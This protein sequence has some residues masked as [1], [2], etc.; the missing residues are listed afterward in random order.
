MTDTAR[1][2]CEIEI[3]RIHEVKL[4]PKV[5]AYAHNPEIGYYGDDD[6][7][8]YPLTLSETEEARDLLSD[9]SDDIPEPDT[10]SRSEQRAGADR[11]CR[12]WE[13]ERRGR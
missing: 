8:E 3:T 6:E 9:P 4:T 7:Y 10:L 1:R 2:Y 11:M 5:K 13:S 12:D